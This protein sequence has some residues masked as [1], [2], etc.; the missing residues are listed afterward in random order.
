MLVLMLTISVSVFFLFLLVPIVFAL[1]RLW[2]DPAPGLQLLRRESHW[3]LFYQ[4]R[5]QS[6]MICPTSF[7][8]PYLIHLA[9]QC[10]AA[11]ERV[12]L[13]LFNDHL[14]PQDRRRLRRWLTLALASSPSTA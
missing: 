1:I 14:Q 11:G 3:W 4:Q 7:H 2:R 8:T 9:L 13:L 12:A 10:P 6:V 5:W